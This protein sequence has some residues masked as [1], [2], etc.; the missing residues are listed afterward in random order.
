MLDGDGDSLIVQHHFRVLLLIIDI[1]TKLETK[2]VFVSQVLLDWHCNI[3]RHTSFLFAFLYFPLSVQAHSTVYI[4]A[5]ENNETI[6]IGWILTLC[7]QG[8]I[9]WRPA[10]CS[11]FLR[12]ML[13]KNVLN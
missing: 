2:W 10:E 13:G 6:D 11:T 9:F 7:L 8:N 3:I 12:G 1:Y 4:Q 5:T